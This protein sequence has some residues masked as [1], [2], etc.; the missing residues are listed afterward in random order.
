MIVYRRKLVDTRAPMR[1]L[2]ALALLALVS[3]AFA[4]DLAPLPKA[5]PIQLTPIAPA[6]AAAPAG[7]VPAAA[8]A[9]APAGKA[10]PTLQTA[11][12]ANAPASVSAKVE[13]AAKPQAAS[14]TINGAQ[15]MKVGQQ[16]AQPMAQQPGQPAAQPVATPRSNDPNEA[17]RQ[18]IRERMQGTGELVI[19]SVDASESA[20]MPAP[21]AA[22]KRTAPAKP[23]AN[24][25][26]PGVEWSYD[27]DR[28]PAMWGKLHSSYAMC[29][30][31]RFQSPI[32]IRD[33]VGVD[34]P[35][36]TFEVKPSHFKIVDTGKTF[37]VEYL[38]GATLKVLGNVHRLV[39]IEFRHPAEE[40]INGRSLGM[41]MQLHFRDANGRHAAVSVLLASAAAKENPFIQTLWNHIPLVRNEPIA[42]PEA[43]INLAQI[44]PRNLAYYT[45][46]GSLTSP[47]CTEGVTWYV[48]KTP[49]EV[50]PE[51]IAIF[52]R[53]Y[54]NNTRPVQ[55]TNS[56][57]IKE[58]RGAMTEAG[59][60]GVFEAR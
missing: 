38:A 3:T 43:M 24:R 6:P 50:A 49:I 31:G 42:P 54:P 19:R 2:M 4:A 41:S 1:G 45:Y 22:P 30:K 48:L 39:R 60:G 7:K 37:E 12:S 53:L 8:P 9:A 18:A 47:P 32:D 28:G 11:P 5:D 27:G 14:I 57:L 35:P 52:A 44:L 25:P 21:K 33:G 29:E 26:A 10:S 17:V 36:L 13:P 58:S 16:P 56:R 15:I 34:L 40:R 55:P 20:P 51:Q 46:M 59:G 23:A